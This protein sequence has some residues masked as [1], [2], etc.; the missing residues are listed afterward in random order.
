M[1]KPYFQSKRG[2][3][4]LYQGDSR[5]LLSQLSMRPVDM[6]FADPP[7]FLSN[8]GFSV[9]AGKCVSVN[10]GAWDKSHGLA[11]D[12]EFNFE[13]IKA[14]RDRM[15]ESA[16]IWICGTF[17]NIFSV[18]TVLSELDF[19][20][21]NAV[22]WQKT[23][24]PPNLSCRV[25]THSTEIILWARKQK[26]V[27]HLF[28]YDLMHL[29]AGD[30]QMTDV[31]RM[32]AISPWEK[33]FGKHPTQ[34]PLALVVRAILASSVE[35]NLILDPFA[36]SSTTGIAANLVNRNFIGIEH[37]PAYLAL[38]KNRRMAFDSLSSD[39]ANRIG[40]LKVLKATTTS[41]K[42]E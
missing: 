26:K 41:E 6:V 9:Q 22:T 20:I 21:L 5:T 42:Q 10:K 29:L 36:G 24:P 38:S 28:N 31:W 18:A 15:S 8:G 17:H 2:D 12:T 25:L 1:L 35:G 23:N 7:Y 32:P 16:T 33:T 40:D 3:F 11:S 27:S 14:C 13:W 37:E 30:R 34:K 19:R 4:T 39:W